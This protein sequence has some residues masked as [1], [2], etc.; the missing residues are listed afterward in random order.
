MMKIVLAQC[1]HM[2]Y[3][4]FMKTT[5]PAPAAQITADVLRAALPAHIRSA[6]LPML[7]AGIWTLEHNNGYASSNKRA[8]NLCDAERALEVA[9]FD[10][11]R[12]GSFRVEVIGRLAPELATCCGAPSPDLCRCC[13][14]RLA[15]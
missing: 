8:E 7:R 2:T 14:E 11:Y 3:G 1:Y 4:L 9:G 10:A 12:V 15:A 13:D 6:F 5:R